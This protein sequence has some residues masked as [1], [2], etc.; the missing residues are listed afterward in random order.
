[1]G[2]FDEIYAR[3]LW[4]RGSGGGADPSNIGPYLEYLRGFLAANEVKSVVDVGCGDWRYMSTV[5]LNGIRYLGV[6]CVAAVVEANTKKH[7]KAN[8]EFV[9]GDATEMDL[10]PADLLI[11]KDVFQHLPN[12]VILGFLP[13]LGKFRHCL[14]INDVGGNDRVISGADN[15]YA[16]L[17]CQQPPFNLA[18]QVVLEM[19]VCC[20][21]K[22]V[23][24]V[25]RGA[26]TP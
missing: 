12:E 20:V 2:M 6:D 3:D 5:D 7:A 18:G 23:L 13:Q 14:I 9:H 11:C 26:D 15:N 24:H 19:Q 4:W 1:M 17:D 21:T 16:G 8:V 25:T 10:P 22:R